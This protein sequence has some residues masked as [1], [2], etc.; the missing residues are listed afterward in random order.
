MVKTN[1][2]KKIRKRKILILPTYRSSV[3]LELG[4]WHGTARDPLA[5]LHGGPEKSVG[6]LAKPGLVARSRRSGARN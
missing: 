2:G 3:Y 4:S 1:Q 6:S 5:I